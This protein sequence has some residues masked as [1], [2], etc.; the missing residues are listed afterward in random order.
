MIE[1]PTVFI[2][3]AG[4]SKPYGYPTGDEL[5]ENIAFNFLGN[6]INKYFSTGYTPLET[7]AISDNIK[8]IIL[9]LQNS[10]SPSIDL[11]LARHINDLTIGK[12][13]IVLHLLEYEF[14]SGFF[15]KSKNKESD[16]YTYL[17]RHMT[18]TFIGK[19]SIEIVKNNIQFITFNYD[20]S[21]EHFL[22]YSLINDFNISGKYLAE[23]INQIPIVHVFGKI[24]D[25]PWEIGSKKVLKHRQSNISL[26]RL[27][28]LSENISI[29]Y[30]HEQSPEIQK[31][32][33]LI[34]NAKR[35]FFIGFG[36]HKENLKV[37]NIPNSLKIDQKIYAT[38][39]GLSSKQ[40]NDAK[41][42]FI[43][44][45]QLPGGIQDNLYNLYFKDMN[46]LELLIEYL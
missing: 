9:K 16:W 27:T 17:I 28:K 1:E 43:V 15:Y 5:K 21:L 38:T 30:E 29:I 31:A 7:Q 4:A 41:A 19:E 32:Q 24:A 10:T 13:A 39:Y 44:N 37:L 12:V 20:R 11:W 8:P 25:L 46:A 14:N 3:G 22:Y 33:E 6:Y 36:F 26:D 42:N 45:R 35:I 40:I 34:E 23:Q 18:N 2:L